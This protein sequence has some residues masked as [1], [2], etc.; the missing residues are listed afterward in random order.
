ML[1]GSLGVALL[2]VG[3]ATAG[4]GDGKV[5]G[6]SAQWSPSSVVMT[7]QSGQ[8]KT[9]RVT[10]R[11]NDDLDASA[12]RVV[13]AL[14]PYLSVAPTSTRHLRK[15]Q[16][17]T[18]ALT[19]SVRNDSMA[20]TVTG[21][22]QLREME[23]RK[24][25]GELVAVPLPIALTVVWPVINGITVP[26]EPTPTVNNST[27]AGVD[28]NSNGVRDDVE[29]IIAQT[30]GGTADY[31]YAMAYAHAYQQEMIMPTPATRDEALVLVANEIC[32]AQGATALLTYEF[33]MGAVT[34]NTP[35]RAQAMQS[36]ADLV[37]G[38]L[39]SE[40]PPCTN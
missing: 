34:E 39:G 36:F 10:L 23:D 25:V 2:G 9:V 22:L 30:F 33:N 11:A 14:V 28:L 16:S 31:P 3:I 8:S 24:R 21:T 27:L 32:A 19:F 35:A 40:L 15:G 1:V 4:G 6:P 12:V 20:L 26:P 18:F 38:F 17:Q 7:L 5:R 37:S 13:P 29:R